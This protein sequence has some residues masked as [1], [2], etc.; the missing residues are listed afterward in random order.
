MQ[1]KE[2]KTRE[3]SRRDGDGRRAEGG[4]EGKRERGRKGQLGKGKKTGGGK[5]ENEEVGVGSR[6][7][8]RE[9]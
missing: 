2:G 9:D 8:K 6:R 4:G 7:G 1:F 3:S 5:A